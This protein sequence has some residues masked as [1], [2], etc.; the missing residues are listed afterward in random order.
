MPKLKLFC[1]AL[2]L[3]SNASPAIGLQDTNTPDP[4]HPTE[5]SAVPYGLRNLAVS[6]DHL[7]G[8]SY[9][10]DG[11]Q[12][13]IFDVIDS[14]QPITVGAYNLAYTYAPVP[15]DIT[16]SKGYAYITDPWTG[17]SLEIVN[18]S[19]PA[20]PVHVSA[21]ENS[22]LAITIVNKHAYMTTASGGVQVMDV[23]TPANG[24]VV[25]SYVIPVGDDI[26]A[27]EDNYIFIACGSQGLYVLKLL[28]PQA[29]LQLVTR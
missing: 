3:A 8:L 14:M 12:L 2:L 21:Y 27:T 4:N 1:L 22:S 26:A 29:F 19:N 7:Y 24:V 16:V 11:T 13:L 5:D 25:G 23:T 17:G 28:T 6:G 10:M 20:R 18:V 9:E 15:W